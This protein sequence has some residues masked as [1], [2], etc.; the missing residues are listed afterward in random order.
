MRRPS[1]RRPTREQMFAYRVENVVAKE[2]AADF[3]GRAENRAL[4]H[5]LAE[6][7]RRNERLAKTPGWDGWTVAE[8]R[9]RM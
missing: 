3:G 5:K 4:A 8:M 1:I 9:R 7:L 6:T 2:I